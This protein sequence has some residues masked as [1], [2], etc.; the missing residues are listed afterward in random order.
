MAKNE[1]LVNS[2]FL[3]DGLDSAGCGPERERGGQLSRSEQSRVF[4][5]IRAKQHSPTQLSNTR[6]SCEPE[7]S[8]SA[9]ATGSM[10]RRCLLGDSETYLSAI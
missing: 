2:Q 10:L 8:L 3:R 9:T 6:C 1:D 7:A 5:F 4:V